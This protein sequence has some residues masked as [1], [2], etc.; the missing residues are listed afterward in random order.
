MNIDLYRRLSKVGFLKKS[1]VFKFLFVAFIGIH[2]PL[3]GLLFFIL[4]G[5]ITFSTTTILVF[6]LVMTLMATAFTLLVLRKLVVPIELASKTLHDYK[7]DRTL[8]QLPTNFNDEAGLLMQDIHELILDSENFINEKKDL[9][10]LLSHDLKNF[11]GNPQAL[12][13]LILEADPPEEIREF[14]EMIHHSTSQQF[15]YL[16]KFLM[17]LKEQDEA[18]KSNLLPKRIEFQSVFLAVEDQVRQLMTIKNIL[19]LT[20]IEVKEADL[21]IDKELLIR[22]MVNLIDNA[23]KFS[24]PDSEIQ[25]RIYS[26][27]KELYITVSDNGMGFDPIY[28]E[29]LFDK[30]TKMSKLG[31]LKEASTGIGL[32]LCKKIVEKNQGKLTAF[33]EGDNKGATFS[34]VFA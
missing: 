27:N 3:I 28:S 21:R 26:K 4:F 14:A 13:K 15:K 19:L 20:S 7:T 33:S 9:I 34:I 25:L 24:F 8:S 10:Y 29:Q 32:Y 2:I 18:I 11:A 17:L 16:E 12:A 30:F 31:T 1:Y 22:V 6:T 5:N 23:I